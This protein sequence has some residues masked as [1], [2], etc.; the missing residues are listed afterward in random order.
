MKKRF[1]NG[2]ITL[3]ILF[4][5]VAAAEWVEAGSATP[6]AT[7]AGSAAEEHN[8]EGIHHY[9]KGQWDKAEQHFREATKAD[10]DSAEAH[11]NLALS[12]DK[13]SRHGE[14]TKNFNLAL[15]LAP[16]NPVIAESGILKGHLGMD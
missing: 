16:N 8:A 7:L 1:K 13:L 9:N 10:H 3:L 2:L 4:P 6:L 11:Y 5:L 14:A 15:M 12:L